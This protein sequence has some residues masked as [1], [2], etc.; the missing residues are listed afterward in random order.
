MRER[1]RLSLAVVL[2]AGLCAVSGTARAQ[3]TRTV[4]GIVVDNEGGA[5]IVGASVQVK[6][7]AAVTT[8]TAIA[9]SAAPT[10]R[11]PG[12]GRLRTSAAARAR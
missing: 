1:L 10:G 11:A 8:Q 5:G 4:T 2:V 9:K 12:P 3:A 6:D 7:T